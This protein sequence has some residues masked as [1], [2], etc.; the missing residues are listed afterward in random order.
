MDFEKTRQKDYSPEF[1]EILK[2]VNEPCELKSPKDP[3][4]WLDKDLFK[5]GLSFLWNYYFV[6][7]FSSFQ[8]LVIGI[9]IP[10]LWLHKRK[11]NPVF[12]Q[13]FF[14]FSYPLVLTKKSETKKKAFVRYTMTGYYM[15]RL[16]TE[17]PWERS[18]AVQQVNAYHYNAF[19]LV[20][21][22]SKTEA[23]R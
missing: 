15:E 23:K 16:Y 2:T 17:L 22:I 18:S 8:N 21:N 6:I 3:P 12:W 20:K 13:S 9:S 19:D 7:A 5:K 4:E 10:S 14:C 1:I 11:M